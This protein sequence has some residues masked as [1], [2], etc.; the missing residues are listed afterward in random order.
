[1]LKALVALNCVPINTPMLLVKEVN[2]VTAT[3][4]TCGV[5]E[6]GID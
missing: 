3:P 1:M 6:R 2:I 5:R 4:R